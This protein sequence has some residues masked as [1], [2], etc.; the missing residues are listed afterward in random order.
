MLSGMA[1]IFDHLRNLGRG[2]LSQISEGA[3][4]SI[5]S[6]AERYDR[7]ASLVTQQRAHLP[8]G[9]FN[10]LARQHP[11]GERAFTAMMRGAG[12]IGWP[13]SWTQ[14]RAK[15]AEMFRRW[16]FVGCDRICSTVAGL[17]PK[18]VYV[19]PRRRKKPRRE[20]EPVLKHKRNRRHGRAKRR[21]LQKLYEARYRKSLG[22]IKPHEEL[23]EVGDDHPCMR[24]LKKPNAWDL[25]PGQVWYELVLFLLLTGNAYLWIVPD[26]AFGKPLEMWVVPSQWV[27]GP[28]LGPAG[29][30]YYEIMPYL[31][32]A[33]N[34][35]I[36][37]EEIVHFAFKN[38]L[39]KIDGWSPIQ[40]GAAW[41][42]VSESIDDSR[43]WTFK[44]GTQSSGA[45]ELGPKYDPD[46][47]D[48]DGIGARFL[49]R[50]QGERNAG[51]PIVLPPD[52]KFVPLTIA[53][54]EMAFEGGFEQVRDSILALLAVPKGIA[55]I[56]DPGSDRALW[57]ER[58]VFM[59]Q[60][61]A[62]RLRY[63]GE[64]FTA[65]VCRRWDDELRMYWEDPTPPDPQQINADI[66]TDAQH[67][68]I[69]I[70]QICA[71]RGRE[72]FDDPIADE[73]LIPAGL[74]PLSMLRMQIDQQKQAAQQQQMQ[75]M[76][77]QP[78]GGAPDLAAL[79]G[80][81]SEQQQ[82]QGLE[83]PETQQA[84]AEDAAL[85]VNDQAWG[86]RDGAVQK[87]H[88]YN[89]KAKA[90]G[91]RW[92][93]ELDVVSQRWRAAP[94]APSTNGHTS[95]G[96]AATALLERPRFTKAATSPR[97]VAAGLAVVA[98]DTGRALL[99]QRALDEQGTNGG[100]WEFPGGH[101]N[102]GESPRDAALREW[103][104]ETGLRVPAGHFAGG[105]NSGSGA[106]R[107]YVYRVPDEDALDLLDRREN[108]NP[109]G[110]YF[111]ALA[112]VDPGD[113]DKH[114]LRPE[115]LSDLTPVRAALWAAPITKSWESSKHPRGQ[116]ENAGE[117]AKK[118]ETGQ[119]A[120]DGGKPVSRKPNKIDEH[121]RAL[122]NTIVE[123]PEEALR[124]FQKLPPGEASNVFRK[125]S[126]AVKQE[127]DRISRI[128]QPPAA[129]QTR[130]P[131]PEPAGAKPSASLPASLPDFAKEALQVAEATKTG[132]FGDN[133]VFINHVYRE[134]ARKYPGLTLAEFKQRLVE[135]NAAGLLTLSRADLPVVMNVGD[136]ED[137]E[138]RHSTGADLSG[139]GQFH[140]ILSKG[141]REQTKPDAEADARV[142]AQRLEAL[143]KQRAE[144]AARAR[145]S[146]ET[147]KSWERSKH[148]RG[149]NPKNPGEFS[150]GSGGSAVAATNPYPPPEPAE[151]ATRLTRGEV[152]P[153]PEGRPSSATS[154]PSST[155]ER[156]PLHKS[157]ETS[158]LRHAGRLEGGCN[159]TLLLQLA[160]GTQGVFK[161]RSGEQKDMRAGVPNGTSYRR[162]IAASRLADV[163][164]LDDLVPA[165]TLRDL[166]GEIGSI[167]NY[168]P[169]AEKPMESQH[170]FDGGE[171]AARAAV[172]DYLT[173]NLDRHAGN[174]LLKDDKLVLID[175]GLSFP[176]AYHP[177]DFFNMKFWQF[178]AKA[179]LPLPDLSG[180]QDKWPRV[181][182]ELRAAG[183]EGDAIAK[184]KERFDALTSGK[185]QRIEDLPSPIYSSY[186][187]L[188]QLTE[189]YSKEARL[190]RQKGGGR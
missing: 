173:G 42:D 15:Q 48:I 94:P 130:R 128:E 14:N 57:G 181:E 8:R 60:A 32:G 175:N 143:K 160:D 4:R 25:S 27:M 137:S 187:T 89:Q 109:D 126:P 185:Y 169:E 17:P 65:A 165:T 132:G 72:P 163:L 161:P 162:E 41:I 6:F 58:A 172:F 156:S 79:A 145:R 91:S 176:T 33:G 116:P 108:A 115:L 5:A 28:K 147:T 139:R 80:A 7:N 135:A 71:I 75:A 101:L 154:A 171:D 136:V 51:Q 184:T 67:G 55:G 13:A 127:L 189:Q 40:S 39:N 107:G 104:E 50:Y 62:P 66:N 138:T 131:V 52:V 179:H 158:P 34:F 83:S 186:M 1:S 68:A 146:A 183:L 180:W 133:K 114:N 111:E 190:A 129:A 140:F 117:F 85:D 84:G 19:R 174:W 16:V 124:Y 166:G 164:G 125:L 157:L 188:G 45:L 59:E 38:P 96:H 159:E 178:S 36:P 43:Y 95:N 2:L 103:Q 144:E 21:H 24:M 20:G 73:P 44:Q 35:T 23:E 170:P 153:R 152:R 12:G 37:A 97:L 155:A 76:Q 142:M 134:M 82:S 63:I 148:P 30:K 29:A 46:D 81:P 121:V 49:A 18:L 100:K 168:V 69:S 9:Q 93:L 26:K 47:V 74:Q 78:G 3:A 64:T 53:P 99:L 98:D 22:A 177:N 86:D 151:D 106:Y 90:S 10:R 141:Q 54:A 120:S 167:Q 61:I 11:T 182:E 102:A 123:D 122:R 113:F 149:G 87:A 31:G 92:R 118:D 119:G 150:R 77:T 56:T 112:W 105:W 88:E 110:D 70:N